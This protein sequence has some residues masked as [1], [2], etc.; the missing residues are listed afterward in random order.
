[1]TTDAS[2]TETRP[3]NPL[4]ALTL[5]L[6]FPGRTFRRLAERPHWIL[7]LVFVA[8]AVVI[9]GLLA[10]S[11]GFM[12]ER[13][14]MESLRTGADP[15]EIRASMPAFITVSGIVSVVS[16]ALLQTLLFMVIA[17][18]LGGRGR[19]RQALSAVCYASVPIGALSLFLTAL[20]P[21]S[22]RHLA[23]LNLAF[24]TDPSRHPFIWGLANQLDLSS[25][26]FFVL[27]GMAAEPVFA[28]P[29]RKARWAAVIFGVVSVL[30]LGW[31]GSRDAHRSVNPFSDWSARE[32]ESVVLRH[33]SSVDEETLVEVA[34]ACARAADRVEQLTGPPAAGVAGV[35]RI[36][37][38]VYPSLDE[39]LRVTGNSAIAH[40]VDWAGAVHV[41]WVGGSEAALTRELFKLVSARA[42]GKVYTPL[43]RDGLA[44][45]AG[46]TWADRPVREEGA[47]LLRRR[48]LPDLDTLVDAAMFVRL[49]ERLSQ[50]AAGSLMDFLSNE[51]GIEVLQDLYLDSAGRSDVAGPLIESALGDSLDAVE[52]RWLEYLRSDTDTLGT[53]AS[54][55]E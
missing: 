1:M 17:R 55:A 45:Y 22:H 44:V 25:I 6:V 5:V 38:Y 8:C 10:L 20:V 9:S 27:L 52:E 47:D 31:M 36:D 24:T 53:R 26:W 37:C 28:L 46:R 34:G 29:R 41:A 14:E 2:S 32:S 43:I 12:D 23:G 19:F 51:R 35:G 33:D 39:K 11:A 16:A 18:R 15:V 54:D 42:Q 7:P 30:A 50:P 4:A 49:D 3:L 40:R 21:F 13:I 48:V